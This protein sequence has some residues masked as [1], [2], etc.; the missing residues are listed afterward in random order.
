MTPHRG[1]SGTVELT[2]AD[3]D[4]AISMGSGDVPVLASPRVVALC[5]QAAVAALNGQLA[6]GDTSVGLA[7]DLKH[8]APTTVGSVVVAEAGLDA[9]DGRR[10]TFTCRVTDTATGREV[11]RGRH[12]RVV[13][14][15]E[16]FLQ[17]AGTE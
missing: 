14:N 1:N 10:L 15:L 12:V 17:K 4:T 9:V 11:A 5:E 3:A 13:V 7:I 6:V 8:F 2:V 16:Q